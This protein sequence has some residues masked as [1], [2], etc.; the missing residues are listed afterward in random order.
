MV[1]DPA[2]PDVVDTPKA[3]AVTSDFASIE[4]AWRNLEANAVG[5]VFQTYDFMSAWTANI[6][7]SR[8][9]EPRIVTCH[10]ADRSVLCLLPFGVHSAKGIRI[11]EWLGGEHADYHGGLYA[12]PFLE[13]LADDPA[14]TKGFL[15]KVFATLGEY[16]LIHLTRQPETL[17]GIANPFLH[18]PS[19]RNA[20]RAHSTVLAGDWENYYAS[21]AS[22][23]WRKTDRKKARRLAELGKVKVELAADAEAAWRLLDVLAEQKR[24]T[25][26]MRGVPDSFA[27]D[28]VKDFYR[29]LSARALKSGIV[30]VSAL[31]CGGEV[32]SVNFGLVYNDRY[33]YVL[34]GYDLGRFA[35]FSPGR[36]HMYW[37]LEDSFARGLKVF[38]FTI[39]DEPYKEQWCEVTLELWNSVKAKGLKG[40]LLAR[41]FR[42]VETV[43]REIK[44]NPAYWEKAVQVRK[45]LLKLRG[46][47]ANQPDT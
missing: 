14:K 27:P 31:T 11:I 22:K 3:I 18:L 28:G 20:N 12:K 8:G 46:Q 19:H 2:E 38:D 25:L 24:E 33:Y 41:Y 30:E 16:D 40:A 10:G 23:S 21:K 47:P 34:T 42:T 35:D 37:L 5:H 7:R 13:A 29:E 43:K 44:T 36:Q 45:I 4:P 17:E 6:G 9:I 15:D 1:T 39:G 26:A 32:A